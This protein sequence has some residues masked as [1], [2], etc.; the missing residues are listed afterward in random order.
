MRWL[1]NFPGGDKA[2]HFFLMDLFA[3]LVNLGLL[4]R[5]MQTLPGRWYMGSLVV[6]LLVTIEEYSQSLF[7]TR[8]FD[9]DDLAADLLGIFL[10]GSVRI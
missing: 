8:S 3:W 6:L 1:V 9:A 4:W 7:P 5:K 2:D 10:L